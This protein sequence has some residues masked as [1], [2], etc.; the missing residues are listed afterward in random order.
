MMIGLNVTYML[1]VENASDEKAAE[2]LA[3]EGFTPIEEARKRI[4]FVKPLAPDGRPNFFT[5]YVYT[6]FF[7]RRNYVL[8]TFQKAQKKDRLG[9]FFQTLYLNPY[10]RSTAT[11]KTAFS[12]I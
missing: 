4:R 9:E 10:S 3:S 5:P 8:P 1:N 2:Y 6:Y 12:Q 11:W 7:G